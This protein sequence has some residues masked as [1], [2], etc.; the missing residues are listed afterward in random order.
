[1]GAK[2]IAM[3]DFETW[4]PRAALTLKERMSAQDWRRF[5]QLHRQFREDRIDIRAFRHQM[6]RLAARFIAAGATRPAG[7]ARG[8]IRQRTARGQR[9]QG[10]PVEAG[11]G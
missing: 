6:Q 10:A 4:V 7:V 2:E 1:M 3:T 5:C 11:R 9:H 8:S